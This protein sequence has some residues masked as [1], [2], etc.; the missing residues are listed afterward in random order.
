MS[1]QNGLDL[2]DPGSLP[3]IEEMLDR[4]AADPT[5]VSESWR[6]FFRRNGVGDQYVSAYQMEEELVRGVDTARRSA[7]LVKHIVEYARGEGIL[8]VAEGVE[9]AEELAAVEELGV[10]LAQGY[11]FAKPGPGFATLDG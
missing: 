7:R 6:E 11:Y 10:H 9:R 2:F 5:S 8:V 1:E 4:Y 3:F